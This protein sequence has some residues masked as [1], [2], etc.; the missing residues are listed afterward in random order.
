M[1]VQIGRMQDRDANCV[2]I[3]RGSSTRNSWCP[4][5]QSRLANQLQKIAARPGFI[6]TEHRGN[7]FAG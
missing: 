4:G 2:T 1:V 7:G 3:K 6:L 5:E